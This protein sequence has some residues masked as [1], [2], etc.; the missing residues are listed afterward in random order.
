MRGDALTEKAS[1][2]TASAVGTGVLAAFFVSGLCGLVGDSSLEFNLRVFIP[3]IDHLFR[4]RHEIHNAI[5]Q[6]FRKAGGNGFLLIW[7]DEKYGGQ[8]IEDF[9]Y[10]Q[11]IMEE[12]PRY[13]EPGFYTTLQSRL[14]GPYI[15]HFGT[16]EKK[17]L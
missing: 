6:A 15:Q 13:G 7:A 10:E 12:T 5:D 4:V 11:V 3:H 1:F 2:R 8:G 14:V 17:E 9:R 16:Q